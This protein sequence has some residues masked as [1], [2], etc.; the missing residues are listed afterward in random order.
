MNAFTQ[1]SREERAL[2][3][4]PFTA[5]VTC[6][7]VQGHEFQY[8]QPCPIAVA[9]L[10]AVMALQPAVRRTLP[11]SLNSGLTRWLEENKAVK[12]TMSQNATVLAAVVRPGLLLALQSE[13]VHVNEAGKLTVAPSRLTKTINGATDEIQAIQKAAYLLGRWLPSTGS[14]STVMALLG[15]RP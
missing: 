6:R 3:N 2:Y 8:S 15:V 14:L 4:P 10:S 7:A 9:V 11:K 1:L 13:A 12:V 5:L